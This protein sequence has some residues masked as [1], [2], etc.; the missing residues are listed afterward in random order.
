MAFF[1]IILFLIYKVFV[2]VLSD[3][4]VTVHKTGILETYVRD[5]MP[6]HTFIVVHMKE[7]SPLIVRQKK[8]HL[9]N[10]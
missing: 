3:R 9:S 6:V 10:R 2:S 4:G 5:I 8:R 7:L 1:F